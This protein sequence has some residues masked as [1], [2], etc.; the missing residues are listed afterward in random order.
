MITAIIIKP[1]VKIVGASLN[2]SMGKNL[3][4]NLEVQVQSLVPEDALEKEMNTH[5]RVF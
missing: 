2:G 4:A 3:P 1:Y 5:I